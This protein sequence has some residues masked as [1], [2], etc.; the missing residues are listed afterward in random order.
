L[1]KNELSSS[2]F[3]SHCLAASTGAGAIMMHHAPQAQDSRLVDVHPRLRITSWDGLSLLS[4]TVGSLWMIQTRIESFFVL[5]TEKADL[6]SNLA[7]QC[8]W[9]LWESHAAVT[10]LANGKPQILSLSP[11]PW[12]W[13]PPQVTGLL[14]ETD[15][16]ED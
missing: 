13:G 1:F 2:L 4:T 6:G 12:R 10:P 7:T 15:R 5:A 9:R 3:S 11:R 16:T 8:S 14:M